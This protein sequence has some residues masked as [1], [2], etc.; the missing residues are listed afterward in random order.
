MSKITKIQISNGIYWIEV[1]EAQLYVLCGCPADS[2]K[3]LM[4]SGV[5]TTKEEAGI[6]YETGPNAILL[7]DV[8]LQNGSFSNL[9]EFPVLQMLYH[10]GMIIPDHPGN[11][12]NKPLLIGSNEQVKAQMRYIY[13]GNYGLISESEI[14][15]TGV[16]HEEAQEIMRLKLKF[17]FGRIRPTQKLLAYKILENSP[18]EI[19][20]GVFVR[21]LNLNI[22]EFRYKDETVTVNLNLAPFENYEPPYKLGFHNIK[23]D[24]FAVIHS[25]EGNGWDVN[26]PCMSSILM[27]QGKIYLIDAGPNISHILKSLGIGINEIEGIFHTHTHDDHFAGIPTLMRADH[28]I[29]YFATPLVRASFTK[30]LSALASIKLDNIFKFFDV[31]DLEIETW[32]NI[33][34]LE[35]RPI[36][37]PHPVETTIFF[38]R[39][40][41]PDGFKSYAHFADI[42]SLDVLK[43]MI[44]ENN[45]EPG[46]TMKSYEQVRSKYLMK[47]DLKKLDVG[48][49]A[50]HGTAT[51]FRND[52]SG[53]I[54]LSHTSSGLTDQQKEIGSGVTFGMVDVLI[55]SYQEYMWKNAFYYLHNYFPS[56]HKHQINMLLNNPIITFNPDTIIIKREEC[57]KN[58]Y[59]ILTGSVEMIQ[60]ELGI[61][62]M[63]SAGGIVGEASCITGG[64]SKETYRSVNFVHALQIP[65]SL[66][67]EFVKSNGLHSYLD[68][69]REKREFLHSTWLFS[70]AI[71]F[72][73]QNILASAMSLHSYE[74]EEVI[75]FEEATDIYL[76]KQGGLQIFLNEDVFETLNI[77]DFFGESNVLFGTPGLFKV[78]ATELTKVYKIKRHALHGVP[79][80]YWKLFEIY[81]KR[82]KLLLN[83]GLSS[84]LTF[85]WREAYSVKV[86]EMDDDHKGLFKAA[87]N[88]YEAI[89][90]D[91]EKSV[92]EDTIN[93]LIS[94]TKSHFIKEEKLMQDSNVPHYKEHRKKHEQFIEEVMVLES[95]YR[96]ENVKIDMEIISLFK[97]WIINHILEEDR[98]YSNY[99]NEND[100]F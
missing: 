2:I 44:N 40:K 18:V 41:G 29:K 32:N 49:G 36:L 64:P 63:H 92:L 50:I 45:S 84:T 14:T 70:E 59:L 24:Y 61:I 12:G 53:K 37:S 73:I 68:E 66:Y 13:R 7:S 34:G 74:S 56:I 96:K 88:L 8:L 89:N 48:G 99:L 1:P 91:K 9:A 43:N 21:R 23:R 67:L 69:V 72:P 15:D 47:A 60:H 98:K 57:N 51:D 71:S 26:R 25:G 78:R 76:V 87:N 94:Y 17:A 38:F 79:I 83:P 16:T 28:K 31:H 52:N 10:Q 11:T 22:F 93:F 20:N 100:I 6:K 58:I 19:K 5:I 4:K 46:I 75:S 77:G 35:V 27:Y 39:T 95:R 42:V 3:H 90:S 85:E 81:K 55:S 62:S 33:E 97:D 65:S 30:K 80:V 54:I 82:M 86:R